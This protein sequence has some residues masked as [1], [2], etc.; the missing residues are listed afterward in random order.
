[1][2][3]VLKTGRGTTTTWSDH[4][5]DVP[6]EVV[7]HASQK[8]DEQDRLVR[9]TTLELIDFYAEEGT[10]DYSNLSRGAAPPSS[11]V[12]ASAGGEDARTFTPRRSW[13]QRKAHEIGRA[14]PAGPGGTPFHPTGGRSRILNARWVAL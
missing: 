1:M 14:L 11:G 7:A 2:R 5:A 8:F 3:Q 10:W 9:R 12:I 6:G 4:V 13:T